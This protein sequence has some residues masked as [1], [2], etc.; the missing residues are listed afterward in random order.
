[1]QATPI[2]AA[3]RRFER[4]AMVLLCFNLEPEGSRCPVLRPHT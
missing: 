4:K 3:Q 1:M 2:D